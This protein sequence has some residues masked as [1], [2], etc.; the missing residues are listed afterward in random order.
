M[1]LLQSTVHGSAKI[2]ANAVGPLAALPISWNSA[3]SVLES[4]SASTCSSALRFL[5][6]PSS[7]SLSAHSAV[8]V[9]AFFAESTSSVSSALRFFSDSNFA[10]AAFSSLS[11]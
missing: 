5:R 7:F 2:Q 8:S 10:V 11:T 9:R 4:C 1:P 3:A 6:S